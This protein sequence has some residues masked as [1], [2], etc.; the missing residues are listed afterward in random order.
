MSVIHAGPSAVN[1][2]H[3]LNRGLV[4]WWLALPGSPRGRQFRSLTGKHHATLAGPT[5]GSS[6]GRPGGY[7]GLTFDG[8]N[9]A[10]T[11]P[12]SA[13]LAMTVDHTLM[14]WVRAVTFGVTDILISSNETPGANNLQYNL[15]FSTGGTLCTYMTNLVSSSLGAVTAGRW[16]HCAVTYV[17]A[18]T[19]STIY[20]NGRADG[21]STLVSKPSAITY[22][23]S[24]GSENAGS[25]QADATV[26]DLRISRRAFSADEMWAF[27]TLSRTGYRGLL[28]RVATT[29]RRPPAAAA[30]TT[31][32][33]RLMMLG[34]A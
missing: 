23:V 6:A 24:L 10:A 13:D 8:T 15:F 34:V 9:D 28:Q 21:T 7:G 12:I 33:Q 17:H 27:Y 2:S 29:G 20:V 26:D 16:A 25:Q 19:T 30:A 3:P 18:T 11:T 1:W 4:A 14:C 5:W 31:R 32:V 22:Y